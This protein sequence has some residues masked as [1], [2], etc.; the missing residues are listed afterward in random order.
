[1]QQLPSTPD[2]A[3]VAAALAAAGLAV[4]SSPAHHARPL[5]LAAR[6]TMCP[7]EVSV[8]NVILQCWEQVLTGGTFRR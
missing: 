4:H 7:L 8:P 3:G 6:V 5:P 2:L 1:M